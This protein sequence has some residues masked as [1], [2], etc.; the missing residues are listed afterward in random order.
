[1]FGV[2]YAKDLYLNGATILL[3]KVQCSNTKSY[4]LLI[5]FNTLKQMLFLNIVQY[6]MTCSLK[7]LLL[8]VCVLYEQS[9][10]TANKI[11]T[12]TKVIKHIIPENKRLIKSHQDI[13]H[14]LYSSPKNE[15][16][17]NYNY[18]FQCTAK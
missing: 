15:A 17:E 4:I 18:K 6:I 1:M 10:N 11:I 3:D 9:S 16:L 14:S 5:V 13:V 12:G 7:Y 8:L 2:V